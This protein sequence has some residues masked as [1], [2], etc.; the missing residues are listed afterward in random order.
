MFSRFL[1]L[2]T[3]WTSLLSTDVYIYTLCWWVLLLL[4]HIHTTRSC[5]ICTFT[6]THTHQPPKKQIH[7][8]IFFCTVIR[9]IK[10]RVYGYLS[11]VLKMRTGWFSYFCSSILAYSAYSEL[12]AS[13]CYLSL[14]VDILVKHWILTG[15]RCP[16][17]EITSLKISHLF[18]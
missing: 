16:F 6:H 14:M 10:K 17:T 3:W 8:L 4:K 13:R 2:R 5:I 9:K 1:Q 15:G 7:R 18:F 12:Y 11:S